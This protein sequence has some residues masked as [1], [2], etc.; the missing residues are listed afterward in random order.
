MKTSSEALRFPHKYL[1]TFTSLTDSGSPMFQEEGQDAHNAQDA[2][3]ARCH[4]GYAKLN[5]LGTS[6]SWWFH[7]WGISKMVGL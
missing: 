2:P 3:V 7:I 4:P 5:I 6:I 1:I